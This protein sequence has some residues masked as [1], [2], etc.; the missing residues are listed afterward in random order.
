MTVSESIEIG[1]MISLVAGVRY[2]PIPP[3]LVTCDPI[4]WFQ[5][6]SRNSSLV[7]LR[8]EERIF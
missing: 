8:I 3:N 6:T 7:G 4:V 1:D 5:Q 2:N